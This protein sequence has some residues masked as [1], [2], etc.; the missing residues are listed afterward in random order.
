MCIYSDYILLKNWV[1][2]SIL[3]F[4][5]INIV[6][7]LNIKI[8]ELEKFKQCCNHYYTK[9]INKEKIFNI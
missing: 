5:K 4:R 6:K 8:K 3:S 7:F 1:F 9:L 2:V